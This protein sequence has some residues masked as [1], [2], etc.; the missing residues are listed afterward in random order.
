MSDKVRRNQ[1]RIGISQGEKTRDRST[2]V[3]DQTLYRRIPSTHMFEDSRGLE[4]PAVI[5]TEDPN[6]RHESAASYLADTH[7]VI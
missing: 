4:M 6:S 7:L 1:H 2:Y 5:H 3:R